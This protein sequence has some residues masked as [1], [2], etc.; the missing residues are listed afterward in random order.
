MKNDTAR[1]NRALAIVVIL[2][3]ILIIINEEYLRPRFTHL[4]LLNP[5]IGSLPNFVG[6]FIISTIVLGGLIKKLVVKNG[7]YNN[8]FLLIFLGIAIFLFLS[9][10]EYFPFFTGNKIFDINDIIANALGVL[11]AYIFFKLLLSRYVNRS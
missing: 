9:I 2:L 3:F 5:I 10:E 8:R 4:E 7:I 11:S 6:S 1:L